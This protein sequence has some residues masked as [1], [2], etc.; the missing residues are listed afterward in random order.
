MSWSASTDNVGVAGYGEYRGS[1][2]VGTTGQTAATF[3]NLVCGTAYQV[4]VD[5]YDTAGNRSSRAD[6]TATTS[7][8][9]DIDPP[10]TP[11]GVVVGTRTATSIALSWSPSTDDAGTVGYGVYR[12]G[13]RVSTT[14]GTTGIVTGLTCG[15]NYTLG[16]DAYDAA[17][18]RSTQAIVMVATLGCADTQAPSAPTGLTASGVTQTALTLGWTASTDNVGVTGYVV[19]RPASR[20]DR[21]RARR[22]R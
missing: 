2:R 13:S 15:T 4:G 20:W 22:T 7:A 3:T 9:P 11:T 14:A 6:M 21:R 10:S 19:T 1:S 17:G 16:V 18:N 5:A 12:G 8:C